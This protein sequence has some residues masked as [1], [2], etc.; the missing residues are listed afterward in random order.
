MWT[1]QV[2][3]GRSHHGSLLCIQDIQSARS[4]RAR[5]EVRG[6]CE[7]ASS[8]G[9]R[10]L[11]RHEV[12]GYGTPIVLWEGSNRGA[13]GFMARCSADFHIPYEP[14]TDLDCFSAIS[15]IAEQSST[16]RRHHLHPA[17]E[18]DISQ[19]QAAATTLRSERDATREDALGEILGRCGPWESSGGRAPSSCI[20]MF[21]ARSC[22]SLFTDS[23][24]IFTHK[25][26]IRAVHR[27]S[28]GHSY[29]G[30]G[31]G[32]H[33]SRHRDGG[34]RSL[35]PEDHVGGTVHF[36][37]GGQQ[38]C[39]TFIWGTARFT[40]RVPAART[41]ARRKEIL[42]SMRSHAPLPVATD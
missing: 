4:P 27:I 12:R 22:V 37:Q 19:W 42:S 32:V 40:H 9:C 35:G 18:E 14:H 15:P 33:D 7:V 31:N 38:L 39:I 1:L 8:R 3:S 24:C 17:S 36:R 30:A 41:A 16:C 29:H 34:S 2:P 25:D 23:S 5:K 26:N 21:T 28:C 10:Q 20:C 11:D 6:S 13:P